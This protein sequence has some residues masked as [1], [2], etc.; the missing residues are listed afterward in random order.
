MV[1]TLYL[2]GVDTMV[3]KKDRA[4][5]SFYWGTTDVHSQKNEGVLGE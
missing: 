2:Y 4:N 5:C 1:L 3:S